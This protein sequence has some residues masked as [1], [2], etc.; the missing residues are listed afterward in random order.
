MDIEVVPN[1]LLLQ[2][3]HRGHVFLAC[4]WGQNFLLDLGC[5]IAGVQCM[6]ISDLDVTKLP[7]KVTLPVPAAS[8]FKVSL[9]HLGGSC[10]LVMPYCSSF[11]D[12]EWGWTSCLRFH[13]HSGELIC[14]LYL[15]SFPLMLFWAAFLK[16]TCKHSLHILDTFCQLCP[17]WIVPCSSLSLFPVFRWE[18]LH[19]VRIFDIGVFAITQHKRDGYGNWGCVMLAG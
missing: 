7:I 4:A 16:L 15:D 12:S 9:I 11:P 19:R 8:C 13:V 10:C 2:A 6:C 5:G 1:V 14:E 17:L 18:L 3:K